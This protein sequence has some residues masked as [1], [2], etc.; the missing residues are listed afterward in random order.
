MSSLPPFSFETPVVVENAKQDKIELGLDQ[1]YIL[2][3]SDDGVSG[4]EDVEYFLY[5]LCIPP[6]HMRAESEAE[7]FGRIFT[8]QERGRPP[9]FY[10]RDI[11]SNA[12]TVGGHDFPRPLYEGWLIAFRRSERCWNLNAVVSVNPTRFIRHQPAAYISSM[13]AQAIPSHERLLRREIP[14]HC[15]GESALIE[16]DNWIPNSRR[17]NA[18]TSPQFWPLIRSSCLRS[19]SQ[20]VI[21]GIENAG[22]WMQSINPAVCVGGAWRYNL[23]SVETYWEFSHQDP[24]GAVLSLQP[25]LDTF[26]RRA[27]LPRDYPLDEPTDDYENSRCLRLK[28]RTGETL[29]IYAKTNRRIRFEI[30]HELQGNEPFRVPRGGHT[31]QTVEGTFPLINHL[32]TVAATRINELLT[33]FRRNASVPQNQWSVLKF[34]ADV[35]SACGDHEK[36]FE[37]IQIL[38]N[39]GSLVVGR[40]IP[41][42]VVFRNELRRLVR[43]QILQTSNNRYSIMPAYR[44]ALTNL[45]ERGI[46]FLLDPP[47]RQ[48]RRTTQ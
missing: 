26:H 31:S 20:Q 23:R 47:T 9:E 19:I 6:L 18:Y 4:A 46:T 28:T 43:L 3:H 37:L 29:R 21:S 16:A 40:G 22:E 5:Q 24:I 30:V 7:M 32:A 45:Q 48:R 44:R 8:I 36:A 41:I 12:L 33:H 2:D 13:H 11:R 25:L 15:H 42:G 10:R 1:R 27:V 35:Q 14:S 39:N 34:I 38:V 17:W